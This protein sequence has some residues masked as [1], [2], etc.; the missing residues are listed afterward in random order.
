ML[1]QHTGP[2]YMRGTKCGVQDSAAELRKVPS[3]HLATGRAQQM[4]F[5]SPGTRNMQKCQIKHGYFVY[6]LLLIVD[7][8]RKHI[9]RH[10]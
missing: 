7:L 5:Y 8:P 10:A 4:P 9:I 6:V 2:A 1:G 3:T